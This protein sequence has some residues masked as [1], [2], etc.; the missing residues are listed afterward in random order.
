MS[1]TIQL[2]RQEL[3]W[4]TRANVWTKEDYDRY[5]NWLKDI[6]NEDTNEEDNYWHRH[7]QAEYEFL[8]QFSWDEVCDILDGKRDD[9]MLKY[10]EDKDGWSYISSVYDLIIE[11]MREDNYDSDVI[12]TEYADDYDEQI[13]VFVDVFN[14]DMEDEAN[15]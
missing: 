4:E 14:G 10:P 15:E 3:V 9:V 5:L 2:T 8:S 12:D 1:R 6:A 11:Q 7:K 13:D